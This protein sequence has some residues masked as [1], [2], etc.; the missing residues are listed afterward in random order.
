MKPKAILFDKAFDRKFKKHIAGLS[1]TQRERFRQKMKLFKEDIFAP[2]LKTHKL[3]GNLS[4]YFAISISYSERLVF[5][6]PGC[7]IKKER[8]W[9][10]GPMQP[11]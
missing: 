11:F 4:D 6:I 3:K 8:F 9:N 7:C 2:G 5:K 1:A 10:K